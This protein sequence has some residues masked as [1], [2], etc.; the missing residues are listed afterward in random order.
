MDK[1]SLFR[2]GKR[3]TTFIGAQSAVQILNAV[4]GLLL[5]RLLSKPEFAIYSVVLGIQGTITILTDL[6][7]GGA[8]LGLAGQ[9]YTDKE[10]LGS[11]IKAAS[12]IRQMLLMIVTVFAIAGIVIFRHTQIPG[13]SPREISFLALTVL[14]ATQFQAWA[15]YYEVPLILNNRLISFYSPQI[16]AATIRILSSFLLYYFHIISSTTMVI[17]NTLSIVIM[18]ISYRVLSR[19]WIVVPAKHSRERAAEMVRYLLPLIPGSIYQALQGQISLF[20]ITAFGHV[21]Q[22]AEVAAAGRISQLFLLL[23]TSNGVLVTPHFARTPKHLFLKRYVMALSGVGLIALT[24]GASA[25]FFPALYLLLLGAKY[26]NLTAQVQLV[27]YA[28]SINYFAGAMWSVA[29]ARRWIFWWSGSSQVVVL[30][31]IQTVCVFVLPLNSSS[32]VLS[33]SIY[34]ALGA[35]LV[36]IFHLAQGLLNHRKKEEPL[37]A[38]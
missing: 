25:R 33:M 1:N 32:G 34:T 19:R 28:A 31:G 17:A 8:I 10:V 30:I 13:H 16:A 12:R 15:S 20:L 35:L 5:L 6:G 38:T 26:S 9:R 7:F 22:I 37:I 4:T 23:N 29:I 2:L 11:Y 18:G 3:I 36:Q 24:V 14:V 27:V 21:S